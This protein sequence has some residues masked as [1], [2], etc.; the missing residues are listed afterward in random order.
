M[1]F[2]ENTNLNYSTLIISKQSRCLFYVTRYYKVKTRDIWHI[3]TETIIMCKVRSN[4]RRGYTIQIFI[5]SFARSY[6]ESFWIYEMISITSNLNGTV[7][8]KIIIYKIIDKQGYF[9]TR[10]CE[11]LTFVN[12]KNHH[13]S[14]VF[15]WF[16]KFC[17][18][19]NLKLVIH[20]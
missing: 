3:R 18:L 4:K 16:V 2:L 15:W 12:L 9:F 17:T 10:I 7:Y 8:F 13:L 5:Q 14:T 11:L 6:V 19:Q 1:L 20:T